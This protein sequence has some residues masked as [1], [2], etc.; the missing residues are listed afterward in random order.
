MKKI[1]CLILAF[2]L[3]TF[4]LV[5]VAQETVPDKLPADLGGKTLYGYLMDLK[6]N[7]L[8]AKVFQDATKYTDENRGKT[9]CEQRR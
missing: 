3:F 8:P 4:P 5:S 6:N 9:R 1:L 2:A 7:Y